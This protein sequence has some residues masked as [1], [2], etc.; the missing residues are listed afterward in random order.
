M[1]P[2]TRAKIGA[3]NKGKTI[4]HEQRAKIGASNRGKVR[5]EKIRAILRMLNLGKKQLIETIEK[6]RAAAFANYAA[7]K[8]AR[9]ECAL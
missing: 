4:P 1:S 3:A 9:A 2:T 8:A 6:K 7:K 5:S